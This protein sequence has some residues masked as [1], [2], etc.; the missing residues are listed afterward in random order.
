MPKV[1]DEMPKAV[2]TGRKPK[3][4]YDALFSHGDKPVELTQ[5]EDFDC[6]VRTMRHNIYRQS[7]VRDLNIKTVTPDDKTLV[8]RILPEEKGTKAKTTSKQTA[9]K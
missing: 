7:K 6:S 2:R 3:H 8:F 5:G 4:D 9:K 1:L